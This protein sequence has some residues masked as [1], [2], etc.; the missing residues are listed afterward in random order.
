VITV[1]VGDDHVPDGTPIQTKPIETG[2]DVVLAPTDPGVDDGGL[3]APGEDVGRHD[4]DVDAVPPER[5]R[6]RRAGITARRG[7]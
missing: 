2:G 4:P 6:C 1:L 7:R 5:A 3:S